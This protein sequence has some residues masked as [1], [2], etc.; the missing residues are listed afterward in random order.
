MSLRESAYQSTLSYLSAFDDHELK[1]LKLYHLILEEVQKGLFQAVLARCA[2]NQTW[3]AD[4]LGLSRNN[5]REK[6][7]DLG[8][9]I[10]SHQQRR[11]FSEGI[12][13]PKG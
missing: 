10:P 1:D 4:V 13:I 12:M 9:K 3:S 5:L 7:K 8:I 11:V 6:L 2:Y